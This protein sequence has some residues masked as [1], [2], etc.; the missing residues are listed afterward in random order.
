[1]RPIVPFLAVPVLA[2]AACAV[3]S[4]LP[5][6]GG[7][8]A[9]RNIGFLEQYAATSAFRLGL[10]KAVT[11]TPQGDAVLFLRSTGP[12]SFVQDLWVFDVPTR[13]ERVLLTA[14][15]VL[16]GKDEVLTPEE[17]ARRE[18]MRMSSRGISS[19]DLADDGNRLLVP[20]SGR[21][22]VIDLTDRSAPKTRELRS[23]AG[24][25][26]DP[27]FT[28]DG[29]KV[30]SVRGNDL[31]VFDLATNTETR[32][33]TGATGSISHGTA[34]FV[35][36]EE[37]D[38]RRGYWVSPDSR[39]LV[40]QRT[41]TAGLETF[42]IADAANPGKPAQS[43]PY[44]RA[45]KANADV[46]LG[47]MPLGGGATTWVDWDRTAYP[48]L[49]RVDWPKNAPLTIL[50]QNREQTEQ[51]LLKVD[52]ATGKTQTLLRETDPAWIN[53]FHAHWLKD[54]S[55]FLWTTEQSASGS[56]DRP[57]LELRNADGTL[58]ATLLDGTDSFSIAGMEHTGEAV[59][60][61]R[62]ADHKANQV[63]RYPLPLSFGSALR[64]APIGG[65]AP[66]TFHAP[67]LSRRS[68]LWVC[69]ET[70]A[71]GTGAF[72]VGRGAGEIL[73]T[74]GSVA[75]APPFMPA[76]EWTTVGAEGSELNAVVI[77]PRG[78]DRTKKYPVLNSVYGGPHSNVVV[79]NPRSYLLHQWIADQGFIVVA[80]DA[81]GTPNKGRAWE[82]VI[83]GDVI[84]V[85]LAEQAAGTLALCATRPEMDAERI[86]M[87]GWSFGGYFSAIAAA[88][89]PDV[90]KAAVA[91]AP[92]ADWRDYDTHYTERYMGLP[93]A[94]KAGYDA[95]SVLTYAKDLRVPLMIMHG[96]ADDNVYTVNSLRLTD[97]LFRAGRPFEFVPLSG[98][99]HS[100]TEP[101]ALSRLWERA[102]LFFKRNLGDPR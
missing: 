97:A 50:V 66:H 11:P 93:D 102:A 45:G 91:V 84:K 47:L 62:A 35:A 68:D 32:L 21:L 38:R 77:R 95:A 40:Y 78:F 85:P 3:R 53:L 44:P 83:K 52:P 16:A 58:R 30:V 14:E 34:E 12:R 76:P 99:T 92:V 20:L 63:W 75:E 55:G 31:Y 4:E 49:A 64:P 71:D 33:T 42:T 65:L 36:Q 13:S 87:Y 8:P 61:T 23:N 96:T 54:G 29:S 41:D 59:I 7:A 9:V 56:A 5:R 80:I 37:M 94:N 24:F 79:G 86:G 89:R 6:D 10:P 69:G 74:I 57:R 60:L 22:F 26:I 100:V 39:T 15:Q 98:F 18:R 17:L 70:Y 28:P 2:L 51:L 67:V 25:A 73:G 82:R 46:T 48:Y 19:F 43:W 88:R 101:Q 27:R 1:M 72:V 90:F 81:R